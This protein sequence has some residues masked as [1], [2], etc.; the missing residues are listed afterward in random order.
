MEA[1]GTSCWKWKG[2]ARL[3]GTVGTRS[4][5]QVCTQWGRCLAST[6]IGWLLFHRADFIST[7]FE[8]WGCSFVGG[9]PRE[10]EDVEMAHGRGLGSAGWEGQAF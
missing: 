4:T 3:Q 5:C 9:K 8:N 7:S 6:V 2:A 1:A 10:E